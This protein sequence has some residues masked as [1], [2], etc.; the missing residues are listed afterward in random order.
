MKLPKNPFLRKLIVLPFMAIAAYLVADVY[1]QVTTQT[2]EEI[3]KT[4]HAQ[5]VMSQTMDVNGR[6]VIADV[7]RLPEIASTVPLQKV[8]GKVITVGK[9]VYVFHDDFTSAR[10]QCTY[11]H[12]LP[13]ISLNC[14]YV[15]DAAHSRFVSGTT[16]DSAH[17]ARTAFATA[18]TASGWQPL[19]DAVWQ[20]E[21]STLFFHTTETGAETHVTLA[22][23]K[24]LP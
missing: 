1:Q 20:K 12:D 23:Q 2:P 16:V 19:N 3:L 17:T 14:H 8:K 10:G 24:E 13:P 18:A 22:V 4:L 7:W 5:Q 9:V 15:I 6:S 11:P 21:G